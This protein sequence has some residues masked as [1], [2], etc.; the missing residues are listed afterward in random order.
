MSNCQ[1][2]KHRLFSEQ[3]HR[4]LSYRLLF[5]DQRDPVQLGSWYRVREVRLE[6][7]QSPED[8]KTSLLRVV[9]GSQLKSQLD[10]KSTSLSRIQISEGK[11]PTESYASTSN[12]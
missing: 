2:N 6:D 1:D 7:S 5:S 4:C 12:C 11:R 8:Q 9:I 3:R 10:R